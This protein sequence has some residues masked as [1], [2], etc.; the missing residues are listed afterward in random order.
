[1]MPHESENFFSQHSDDT[2]SFVISSHR[3]YD[4]STEDLH[5]VFNPRG[6]LPAADFSEE[7]P[8]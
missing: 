7:F 3:W 5:V 2:I 8:V 6:L 4:D 1:M